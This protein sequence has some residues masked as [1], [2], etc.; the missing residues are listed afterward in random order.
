MPAQGEDVDVE[1]LLLQQAQ[2]WTVVGGKAGAA[3]VKVAKK[4]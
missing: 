4:L 3:A 1:Q 2:K